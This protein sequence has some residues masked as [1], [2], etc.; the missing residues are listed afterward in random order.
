VEYLAAGQT[1][2]EQ[3]T[4]ALNDGHGGIVNQTVSVTITGTND[5]PVLNASQTP[6]LGGVNTGT[7]VPTGAVGT[8]VSALVD[9]TTPPGQVDNVTDADSGA[10]LGIALTGTT[11]TG[12]WYYSTNGGSTWTS[13]NAGVAVS[14]AQ[15]LLLA[16]DST[17]RLYYQSTTAGTQNITFRA[18]DQ[19]TGAA[20]AKV[21]T[22]TNGGTTAFSVATDTANITVTAADTTPPTLNS[23][24]APNLGNSAGATSTV[25]FTFSEAVTNFTLS[26]ITINQ[27][28]RASLSNLTTTDSITWTATATR[29]SANGSFTLTVPS[30]AFTDMAGNANTAAY[31]SGNL[32]PAGVAGEP[33]FLALAD[34]SAGPGESITVTVTGMPSDWTLNAGTKNA[35][36]SWTVHTS[37]VKSLTV[38]TPVTY[39]G[40]LVL[41]VNMTWTNIDGSI[42]TAAVASNVEAYAPDNPIFAVSLDDNLSGSVG[43]DLFVFAQPTAHNKIFAFDVAHDKI[44]LIGFANIHDFANLVISDDAN[45][46]AVITTSAGSTITVLGVHAAELTAANFEINVEPVTVN[47]GR[48]TI[49]DGAILPLGGVIQNSGTIALGSTGSETSLQI[50]VES[51]TLQGHGHVLLSDDANNIIFGGAPSA[52]LINVDNTISGAGQLGAGHMTLDN[53]GVIVADGTHALVIDTGTNVITN[54]GTLE[55]TGTGGLLLESAIANTGALWVNGGKITVHGDVTGAGSALISG[56]STL[57]LDGAAHVTVTFAD[58][59]AGTLKLG[60][61][62][63]FAGSVAGFG[64]GDTLDLADIGFG[65]S[66]TLA[67]LTDTAGSGALVISDGASTAHIALQG[68]YANAGFHAVQDQNGGTVLTV[69]VADANQNLHGGAGMDILVAGAGNDLLSG[70]TSND[71]LFG[72]A[73]NDT[74]VFDSAPNGATNVDTI[75]DFKANGDADQII[76][77]H[78]VFGSLSASDGTLD[79][80]QFASVADGSGGSATLDA[81]VHVIYDSQTGNLYYDANGANTVDGRALFA[82]LGT[83]SHPATVDHTDIKVG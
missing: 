72:G 4:V 77:S 83:T 9:F 14:D 43:A 19:T 15:A 46:N 31:T 47:T 32:A 75:L 65:S 68:A 61:A 6:V 12:T 81:G 11:G 53:Q 56:A 33:I 1:K 30:G 74:F 41:D 22:V 71:V 40:A 70:G 48:M 67:Y 2:V 3:F 52:K 44:D 59:G 36:G 42:G 38:K 76:L 60:D 35:D 55:A 73:G 18:W 5:A 7:G 58:N 80:A 78:L 23:T 8:L 17:T 49:S 64:A 10:S 54:A 21:T 57:E 50:L 13:V 26:D 25:T 79:A 69:N 28:T 20:G 27:P 63:H 62:D 16:A 39:S 37:D 24:S 51:V 34:I 45:G 66:T 82:T 29:G